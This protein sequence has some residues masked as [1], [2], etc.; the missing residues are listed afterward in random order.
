MHLR[1]GKQLESFAA[2]LTSLLIWAGSL[3]LLKDMVGPKETFSPAASW[4]L[5]RSQLRLART[6]LHA[7]AAAAALLTSDSAADCFCSFSEPDTSMLG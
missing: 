1:P 7:V 6:L 2:V 5:Q 4:L 3:C